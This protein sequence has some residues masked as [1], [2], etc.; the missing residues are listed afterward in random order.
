[1]LF[2]MPPPG[3]WGIL[4]PSRNENRGVTNAHNMEIEGF[5]FNQPSMNWKY[6]ITHV[7]TLVIT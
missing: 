5:N 1:M 7:H 6:V 4:L 3:D 2:L